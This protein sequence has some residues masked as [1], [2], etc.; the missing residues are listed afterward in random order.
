M[1]RRIPTIK[2]RVDLTEYERRFGAFDNQQ[3]ARGLA[4]IDRY[5]EERRVAMIHEIHE[6]KDQD[7]MSKDALAKVAEYIELLDHVYLT[8]RDDK[9]FQKSCPW[10][11]K[12]DRILNP[13]WGE[14]W[15]L[16]VLDV[17]R[18]PSD[19]DMSVG[20]DLTDTETYDSDDNPSLDMCVDFESKD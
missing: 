15:A 7:P 1:Q 5:P 12:Y 19:P 11:F 4:F 9:T 6:F 20:D 8:W 2:T 10:I 17:D 13:F 14:P 16:D 3:V 18:T